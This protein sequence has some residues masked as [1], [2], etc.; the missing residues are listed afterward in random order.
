M[1]RVACCKKCGRGHPAVHLK[2]PPPPTCPDCGAETE[3]FDPGDRKLAERRRLR[4]AP[5]RSFWQLLKDFW[6][7]ERSGWPLQ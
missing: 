5:R 7:D 6:H 2:L 4:V 1:I 3:W